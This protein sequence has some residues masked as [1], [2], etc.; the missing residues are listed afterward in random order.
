MYERELKQ[1]L[2][3]EPEAIARYAAQLPES[4]R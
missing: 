1:L 3:G 4:E 2:Q